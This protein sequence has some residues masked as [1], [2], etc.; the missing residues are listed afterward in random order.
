VWSWGSNTNGQLGVGKFRSEKLITATI[1]AETTLD[2]TE[3]DRL[4]RKR[5]GTGISHVFTSGFGEWGMLGNAPNVVLLVDGS[6]AADEAPVRSALDGMVAASVTRGDVPLPE[7]STFSS[8]F[9]SGDM[10]GQLLPLLFV[11]SCLFT[12]LWFHGIEI[13]KPVLG[14]I[15]TDRVTALN[16]RPFTVDADAVRYDDR[17]VVFV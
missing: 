12:W 16:A 1:F 13:F 8:E 14:E 3:K 15:L 9:R 11:V 17:L 10:S 7:F 4:R 6:T 5:G 2:I